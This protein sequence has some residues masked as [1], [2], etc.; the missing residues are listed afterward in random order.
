MA[1]YRHKNS[2]ISCHLCYRI[3]KSKEL[4]K[5]I[6]NC[7][8]CSK[9]KVVYFSRHSVHSHW[10]RTLRWLKT[11]KW[12]TREWKKQASLENAGVENA[13]VENAARNN[14]SGKHGSGKRGSWKRGSRIRML[15]CLCASRVEQ[16]RDTYRL[17]FAHLWQILDRPPTDTGSNESPQS[18]VGKRAD[19][20]RY[21]T[22]YKMEAIYIN[23]IRT[24]L[25]FTE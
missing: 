8:S 24:D 19:F 2:P 16:F 13:G 10:C 12:K 11:G 23:V 9:N 1:K 25:S 21:A 4:L 22:T 18:R 20:C 15:S 14:R 17:I 5:S 7:Q 6:H 3:V